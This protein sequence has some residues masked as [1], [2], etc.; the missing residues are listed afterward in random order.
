MIASKPNK[1]TFKCT[2]CGAMFAQWFGNCSKCRSWNTISEIT[3]EKKFKPIAKQ[4][5]KTKLAIAESKLNPDNEN[6]LKEK[7]FAEVRKKLVGICMC[8]CGQPSQ[9]KDDMFFRSSCCHLFPKRIFHSIKYN[10]DN[11]IE[12]AFFGGCHSQLDDRSM[13]KWVGMSD[14]DMIKQKFITLSKLI[15]DSEKANKFYSQLE[16]LV[17]NN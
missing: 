9:K 11:Y 15:P 4:S 10:T 7:W 12:R 6:E 1:I 5:V 3:I 16:N 17:K 14:W 8:G 2:S 13:D